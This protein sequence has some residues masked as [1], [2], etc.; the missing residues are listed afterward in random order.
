M[1]GVNFQAGNATG[2][3]VVGGSSSAD[4]IVTGAKARPFIGGGLGV[5]TI[6]ISKSGTVA[7]DIIHLGSTFNSAD[8]DPRGGL[9]GPAPTAIWFGCLASQPRPP[10]R[11]R[12][13][14]HVPGGQLEL[15]DHVVHHSDERC[16]RAIVRGLWQQHAGRQQRSQRPERTNLL[17]SIGNLSV[18]ANQNTGYVVAYQ[19]NN[20]YLY[21]VAE[22][23]GDLNANVAAA[24]IQLIGTFN[25]VAVGAFDPSNFLL[26]V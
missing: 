22:S 8:R 26:I 21:F 10:R 5:D 16:P 19:S 14:R 1:N 6:D 12:R 25:N 15:W 4:T 20:A 11:P 9:P 13:H 24:D 3:L 18:S 7:G 17:A 2:T 23:A